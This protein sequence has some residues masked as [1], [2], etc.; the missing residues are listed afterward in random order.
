MSELF[1]L[2]YNLAFLEWLFVKCKKQDL[3]EKCKEF[4]AENQFQLKCFETKFT[5]RKYFQY[6][7]SLLILNHIPSKKIAWDF[8]IETKSS[9]QILIFFNIFEMIAFLQNIHFVCFLIWEQLKLLCLRL[10]Q[11]VVAILGINLSNYI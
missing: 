8:R 11:E 9:N 10:K 2:E 1:K 5:P 4:S 3:V 6:L 7:L